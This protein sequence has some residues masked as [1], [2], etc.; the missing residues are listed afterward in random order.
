MNLKPQLRDSSKYDKDVKAIARLFA[1]MG[2]SYIELIATGYVCVETA[3]FLACLNSSVLLLA[4]FSWS[5]SFLIL[6][7]NQQI[8]SAILNSS[9]VSIVVLFKHPPQHFQNYVNAHQDA[10]YAQNN[11]YHCAIPVEG[12]CQLSFMMKKRLWRNTVFFDINL[13]GLDGI[14]G[15]VYVGT[16]CVFKRSLYG[17]EL[18]PKPKK[19]REKGFLSSCFCGSQKNS[20]FCCWSLV[21]L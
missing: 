16:G 18:P 20:S 15:P 3:N 6:Y 21:R 14:Q 7:V 1:D 5:W 10:Y 13:R 4:L 8:L 11:P 17:Y 2:D 12:R 19:K 9:H